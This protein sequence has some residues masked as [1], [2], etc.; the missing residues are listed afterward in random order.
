M[1]YI[2]KHSETNRDTFGKGNP[3]PSVLQLSKCICILVGT[4]HLIFCCCFQHFLIWT[5]Y[6]II[7]SS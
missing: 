3:K 7:I 6:L 1:M 4:L 5:Y 2:Q